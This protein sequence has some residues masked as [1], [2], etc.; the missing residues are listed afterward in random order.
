MI[1]Y[2]RE[3]NKIGLLIDLERNLNIIR[4]VCNDERSQCN[5]PCMDNEL[6]V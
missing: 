4:H 3:K 5:G 2:P 1:I 6:N